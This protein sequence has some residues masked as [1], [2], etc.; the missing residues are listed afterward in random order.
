MK[1]ISTVYQDEHYTVF[2]S[3]VPINPGHLIIAS[4]THYSS[5]AQYG[6][7]FIGG[8]Y[9]LAHKIIN[10]LLQSDT[11]WDGVSLYM[12][13]NIETDQEHLQHTHLNII[14]RLKDD[15]FEMKLAGK[16]RSEKYID[17]S[18]DYIKEAI[19]KASLLPK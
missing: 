12:G 9:K 18:V 13:D 17:K 19:Y 8:L 15:A 7:D 3:H 11:K 2:V 14:P 1:D 4:N 16:E 5:F 10:I 6:E